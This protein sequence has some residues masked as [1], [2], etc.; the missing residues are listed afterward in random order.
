M[1]SAVTACATITLKAGQNIEESQAWKDSLT[2]IS[3]QAGYQRAYWG[4]EVDNADVVQLLVDWD[5]I[6]SNGAFI[7]SP[8]YASF[9]EN[10]STII[11][12]ISLHHVQQTTPTGPHTLLTSA[13]VTEV[14]TLYACDPSYVA[15]KVQPFAAAIAAAKPAGYRG[16][17]VGDVVEEIEKKDGTAN[18]KGVKLFIGWDSKELHEQAKASDLLKES[19]GLLKGGSG[20]AEMSY[21]SFKLF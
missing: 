15:E 18:G 8:A 13:P 6:A 14:L 21:V 20:G 4:R 16:Y 12:D 1:A 9:M 5:S 19:V 11:T 17:V 3:Q 7:A 10:L 2:T